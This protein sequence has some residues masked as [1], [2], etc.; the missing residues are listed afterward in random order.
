MSVAGRCTIKILLE[1]HALEPSK[2]MAKSTVSGTSGKPEKP[3]S[4]FVG[5]GQLLCWMWGCR[6]GSVIFGTR[7]LLQGSVLVPVRVFGRVCQKVFQW[8][9]SLNVSAFSCSNASAPPG[10]ELF[11]S[12]DP[13]VEQF[14]RRLD[15]AA[16]DRQ[17]GLAVL[18]SSALIPHRPRPAT[19]R[20]AFHQSKRTR[21]GLTPEQLALGACPRTLK[22]AP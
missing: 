11:A 17:I 5:A 8:P 16:G 10:P 12:L 3:Y 6:T 20:V 2:A 1:H 19:R 22:S 14:D 4:E 18:G 21:R 15:V 7:V 13:V 9:V